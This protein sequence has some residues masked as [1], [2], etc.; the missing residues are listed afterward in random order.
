M[1]A[2][3]KHPCFLRVAFDIAQWFINSEINYAASLNLTSA[4]DKAIRL[5][6]RLNIFNSWFL[7]FNAK[8]GIPYM[9]AKTDF[10]LIS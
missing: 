5:W 10:G 8:S 6:G 2:R 9:V 1:Y 7:R 4:R 3:R